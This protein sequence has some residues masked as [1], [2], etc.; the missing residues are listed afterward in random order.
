MKRIYLVHKDRRIIIFTLNSSKE[1]SLI[2][3]IVVLKL[4]K[5]QDF[6]YDKSYGIF[7]FNDQLYCYVSLFYITGCPNLELMQYAQFCNN[8]TT[9]TDV[10]QGTQTFSSTN[11]WSFA[12][13]MQAFR[14]FCPAAL[15]LLLIL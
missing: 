10:T 7:G 8:A 1:K 15:K 2:L 4:K 14:L 12:P 5:L 11:K 3:Y 9:N 6:L 13:K